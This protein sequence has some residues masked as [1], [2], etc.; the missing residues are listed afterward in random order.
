ME[1]VVSGPVVMKIFD[2]RD[3]KEIDNYTIRHEPVASIDLMERAAKGCTEWIVKKFTV[4]TS[5]R[6]FTGP[7]NNGGDGWAIARLLADKGYKKVEL[8]NL[9]ISPVISPDS[10]L[11]R[12]RLINQA[13]IPVNYIDKPDQFPKLIPTDVVIDALFGSGLSRPLE[14]LSFQ[15]VKHI[16]QSRC[17][18]ISI[19]I[20]SGLFGEDNS[21]NAEEAIIRAHHTLTF[22]FP[23]RSF[24]YAENEK[25]TG[26]WHIIHIGLHPE[27]MQQK[28]TGYFYLTGEMIKPLLKKR[29]KFSHKGLYG[30]GL[31]I[32][33]SYGMMGAAILASRA[34]LRTGVG[35]ITTHV[36]KAGYPVIQ[37]AVPESIFSIDQDENIISK[38]PDLKKFTAVAAGPGIG[39]SKETASAM[40]YLI[41]NCRKPLLLDADALNIIAANKELTGLLPENS[42][43]TPHPGEFDRI[44]GPSQNGYERN[45]KQISLSEKYRLIIVLKGAYTSVSL[46]DGTCFFNSTGNPGMSTAGSG[47]VLT[48]MILSLLAQG[49]SP[50]DAAR[51]GVFIHGLAGDLAL[52]SHSEQ[53]LIA[54]DIVDNISNALNNIQ[55]HEKTAA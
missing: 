37:A 51:A 14:G 2:T 23:K 6:I 4:D 42:V 27:I 17:T 49:Y 26:E 20:P 45:M 47:D 43:I 19:D 16:N 31:L 5:I 55:G 34:C 24:F 18:V 28:K 48:G 33:G 25:F 52:A 15:L 53:S 10:E 12:N 50:E 38:C 46:P 11:N 21:R 54:S 41:R 7:G 13:K 22:Q 3:I 1:P 36:P 39:V 44:A 35:L 29:P 30:H 9:Q 32:A 8:F 40:E